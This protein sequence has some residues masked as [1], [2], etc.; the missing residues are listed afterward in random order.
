VTDTGIGIDAGQLDEIFREFHQIK[1]P[2]R[3]NEGFGL[4]LA[5][6]KRLAD[7]LGHEVAVESDLGNGSTF[8]IAVPIVGQRDVSQARSSRVNHN[9]DEST[10]TGMIVLIEDDV[11]VANA[12]G[13]LLEA[14][15]FR[16]ATAES[17][18]EATAVVKHLAAAPDLI[19]SDFH[20]VDGST[21]VEAVAMVREAFDRNIP[22][23]IVTGDTSKMVQEARSTENCIIM[24]KPVNT[25]HL[26]SNAVTAIETGFVPDD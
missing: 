8:S 14:E 15:G 1:A 17:A 2:G 6:V 10:V 22:A 5:I 21:G 7:L 18:K 25:D 12:W 19:I 26:L 20:L 24:N 23:F 16:V 3:D 4:G 11:N 13:M 9:G